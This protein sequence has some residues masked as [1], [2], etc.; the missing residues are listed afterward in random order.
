MMLA[1]R[2]LL[3]FVFSNL[4]GR[5]FIIFDQAADSVTFQVTD[6]AVF[7][8]GIVGFAAT[9]LWSRIAKARGGKT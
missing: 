2:M 6:L 8:A 1:V 7:I 5:G 3:Y 4:A 9:F